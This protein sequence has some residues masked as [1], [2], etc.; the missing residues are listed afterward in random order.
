MGQRFYGEASKLLDFESEQP[1]ITA[2]QAAW[3]MFTYESMQGKAISSSKS[4]QIVHRMYEQLGLA[5]LHERP[6]DYD[7]NEEVRLRW[8]AIVVIIWGCY[9]RDRCGHVIIF[10]MFYCL[11]ST[12]Y[13]IVWTR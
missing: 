8:D 9:I 7:K 12:S 3:V 4:Y 13:S 6:L 1:S 2:M 5:E 11:G 10:P